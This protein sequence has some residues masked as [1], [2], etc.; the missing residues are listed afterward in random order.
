[1]ESEDFIWHLF[2]SIQYLGQRRSGFLE[3]KL[4]AH[5]SLLSQPTP[6]M[7]RPCLS[8][9]LSRHQTRVICAITLLMLALS[10]FVQPAPFLPVLSPQHGLFSVVDG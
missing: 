9:A 1:M 8:L 6:I 10:S 3:I 2:T 7:P 5:H 4:F